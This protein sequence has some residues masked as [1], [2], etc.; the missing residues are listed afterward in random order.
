MRRT[1][2]IKVKGKGRMGSQREPTDSALIS[3]AF[4]QKSDKVFIKTRMAFRP[5]EKFNCSK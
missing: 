5:E 3:A 1:A 2:G 4:L